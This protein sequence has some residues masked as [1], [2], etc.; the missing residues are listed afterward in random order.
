MTKR[1]VTS[2]DNMTKI[3]DRILGESRK[4]P[5][6]LPNDPENLPR[7]V[8]EYLERRELLRSRQAINTSEK[9][10]SN[11]A[12]ERLIK[13]DIARLEKQIAKANEDRAA[14]LDKQSKV[15]SDHEELMSVDQ[16]LKEIESLLS[17]LETQWLE[18]SEKLS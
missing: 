6:K 10:I 7:G 1:V 2:E 13:K 8:D 9:S 12:Q 16:E 11:A 4:L 5:D 17:S 14:L 15:V 18:L 3:V